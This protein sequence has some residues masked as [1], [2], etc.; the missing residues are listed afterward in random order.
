MSFA[1]G[2]VCCIAAML[3]L[4]P[5]ARRVGLDHGDQPW[6]LASIARWLAATAGAQVEPP[7]GASGHVGNAPGSP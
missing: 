3:A 5:L 7:A 1:L 2:A 6:L 4:L